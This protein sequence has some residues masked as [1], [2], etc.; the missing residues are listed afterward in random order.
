MLKLYLIRHGHA[1]DPDRWEG[2]DD[3]R[4]LSER[5][6]RDLRRTAAVLAKR[7]T[8]DI[9]CTSP[10]VRAVQT[11]EI[12]AQALEIDDVEVLEELRPDA[13][14]QAVLERGAQFDGKRMGFVGHDP[15]MTGLVAA[16]SGRPPH[17]LRFP[18]GAVVR[19]DVSDLAKRQAQA[20]WW[21]APR[22]KEAEEGLPVRGEGD[23]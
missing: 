4:P 2:P 16:L 11:A 13:P 14:V 12:V 1:G 21:L 3:S 6:R 15:Q 23:D 19:F 7:E 22:E 5:G 8:I 17:E 10:L 18:K 9:L 20:R